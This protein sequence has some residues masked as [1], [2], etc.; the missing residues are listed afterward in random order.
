MVL[1]FFSD[2]D[3]CLCGLY[4]GSLAVLWF[5]SCKELMG[6]YGSVVLWYCGFVIFCF[7]T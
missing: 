2:A 7:Y 5:H 4:L 6:G 3:L 1:W